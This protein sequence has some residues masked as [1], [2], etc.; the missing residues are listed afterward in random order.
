[1][2]RDA[3][4]PRRACFSCSVA[5]VLPDGTISAC[6]GDMQ[7]TANGCDRFKLGELPKKS[8]GDISAE[9][10]QNYLVHAMRLWGPAK[11]ADIAVE[12]GFSG[13]LKGSYIKDNV[14]DLCSDLFSIPEVVRA[15]EESLEDAGFRREIALARALIF[16]ELEMI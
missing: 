4:F 1:V 13:R 6:G 5:F 11:L 16:G 3:A 9:A 12:R 7:W 10:E 14:C 2:V 8:F 15:I